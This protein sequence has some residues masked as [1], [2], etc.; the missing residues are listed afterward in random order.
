MFGAKFGLNWLTGS[1]EEYSHSDDLFLSV[2]V[3]RRASSH[4]SVLGPKY[5]ILY[6]VS[7]SLNPKAPVASSVNVFSSETTGPVF[8]KFGM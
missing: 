8:T 3:R 5:M 2:G 7:Y 1:G 4:K 6:M